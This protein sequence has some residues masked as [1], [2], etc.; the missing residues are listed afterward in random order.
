MKKTKKIMVFVTVPDR[1]TA[2][3]IVRALLA[4]KLAAC[5]SISK[6]IDS[7]YWWKNKIENSKELLLT[8]KTAKGNF[9]GLEKCV[10]SLHPYEVPE[11]IAVDI[12]CG[13]KEYLEW[14]DEYAG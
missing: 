2:N 12:S 4:K 7:F 13:S 11:I 3:K 9:A 8:I 14:I 5:A 10:K 1:K 6:S